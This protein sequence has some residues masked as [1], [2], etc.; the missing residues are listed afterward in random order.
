LAAGEYVLLHDAHCVLSLGETWQVV[1][2]QHHHFNQDNDLVCMLLNRH[3]TLL[4][5]LSKLFELLGLFS[6][7]HI[8][9]FLGHL[10]GSFLE[11]DTLAREI[12]KQKPKVNMDDVPL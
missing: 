1:L 8:N 12:G 9:E 7:Q 4:E 10:E 3:E 11:L 2:P 5:Q 6:T